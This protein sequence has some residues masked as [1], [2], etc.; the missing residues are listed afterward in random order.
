MVGRAS[1]HKP[2]DSYLTLRLDGGQVTGQWDMALRDLDY[3]IGLDSDNDGVITWREL[4]DHHAAIASYAFSRLAVADAGKACALRV[5]EHLVDDHSDGAYE[6]LRFAA[7]CPGGAKDVAVKYD[8]LFD[9]DPQHRG[10]LRVEEEGRTHTAVLSPGRNTW[11]PADASVSKWRTFL[12]YLHEGIW[13]IWTGFDHMLFLAAVLLPAV[14][15]SQS[16]RWAVVATFR[17]ALAEVLKVVTAFTLAHSI[18]LTLAVLGWITLPSRL[19]ESAIAASVVAA[20]LNNLYPVVN[21]RLWMVAFA[22]GLIHGL[23]FAN[24][25]AELGLP[26]HAL[27]V[28]LASFNV[29]VEIGQL[30]IVSTFLPVAYLLRGHWLYPRLALGL[31]SFVIVGVASVWLLERSLDLRILS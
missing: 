29:G 28:A 3:A 13:H 11:S 16:G 10:L 24:A 8:L 27:A 17:E 20:A 23:G 18:T 25:L 1:A 2:S 12:D 5:V 4:R 6:I 15:R 30:A 22:F 9:V 26:R 14:L 21:K 19:V 31:G 7:D